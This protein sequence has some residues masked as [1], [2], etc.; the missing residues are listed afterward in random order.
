MSLFISQIKRA[1][2]KYVFFSLSNSIS[3]GIHFRS[4]NWGNFFSTEKENWLVGIYISFSKISVH[5]KVTSYFK[6]HS[7]HF[8][9]RMDLSV[10]LKS[11]GSRSNFVTHW[12]YILEKTHFSLRACFLICQTN[13]QIQPCACIYFCLYLWR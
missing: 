8:K 4:S 10:K 12:L 7:W 13:K 3:Y 2:T 9:R 11:A 6:W 1:N 5:E